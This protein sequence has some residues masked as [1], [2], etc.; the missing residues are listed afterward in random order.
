MSL[1]LYT[2]YFRR[3]FV[4]VF[5]AVCGP[6]WSW[7]VAVVVCGR[8]G[9]GT[10][11]K[12]TTSLEKF[13]IWSSRFVAVMVVVIMVIICGRLAVMV[14]GRAIIVKLHETN[15]H[16][17]WQ[18][19]SVE[20]VGSYLRLGYCSL[21]RSPHIKKTS[22]FLKRQKVQH[23]FTTTRLF[24]ELRI[25]RYHDRQT[26]KFCITVTPWPYR[27]MGHSRNDVIRADLGLMKVFKLKA[28]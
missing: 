8:H 15:S 19:Y 5:S 20:L 7:F 27:A 26:A 14:C 25:L 6:S 16:L 13:H 24:P 18:S 10:G 28:R 23:R 3:Y 1:T 22:S 9:T 21:A 2:L 17:S 4:H 11:P 12:F